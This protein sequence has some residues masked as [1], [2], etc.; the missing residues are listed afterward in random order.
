[1]AARLDCPNKDMLSEFLAG[2]SDDQTCVE[3]ERHIETCN[4]CT[5]VLSRL[6]LV[7]SSRTI[8]E[9]NVQHFRDAEKTPEYERCLKKSLQLDF[10]Y[11]PDIPKAV[12]RYELGEPV[13][14]GAFGRVFRAYD[15]LLDTEVAVKLIQRDILSSTRRD[16]ELLQEIRTTAALRTCPR[17]ATVFDAGRVGRYSYIVSQ[18]IE[19]PRL[20]DV[21]RDELESWSLSQI[22]QV[23]IQI[24]ETLSFAHNNGVVHRDVKP[25]NILL[26]DGEPFL[27]DFGLAF[28]DSDVISGR[29]AGTVP[30]MSPEQLSISEE[31]DYRSDIWSFGVVLYELVAGKRPFSGES[32]TEIRK[33]VYEP[34]TPIPGCVPALWSVI[35]RCLTRRKSKR[36]GSA[37]EIAAD[38]E[39]VRNVLDAPNSLNRKSKKIFVPPGLRAFNESESGELLQLLPGTRDI[40]GI[41]LSVL[42]WKNKLEYPT[43]YE[44]EREAVHYLYGPS[45]AGKSSFVQAALIPQFSDQTEVLWL[46]ASRNHLERDLQD[47]LQQRYDLREP[48]LSKSLILLRKRPHKRDF[49]RLVI[50][51]DQFE[52]WLTSKSRYDSDL[53]DALAHAC[54]EI[55]WLFVTRSEYW[56]ELSEF[57][58]EQ[59]HPLVQE[60][61]CETIKLLDR[62]AGKQALVQLG[63][64]YGGFDGESLAP[65]QQKLV[66]HII[67]ELVRQDEYVNCARLS[68]LAQILSRRQ[69]WTHRSFIEAG[70]LA[71]IEVEFLEHLFRGPKAPAHYKRLVPAIQWIVQQLL[72]KLDSPICETKLLPDTCPYPKKMQETAL[73]VLVQDL[74]LVARSDAPHL[75]GQTGYRIVHEFLGISFRRW[76]DQVDK[77]SVAGRARLKLRDKAEIWEMTQK[78]EHL[79]SPFEWIQLSLLTSAERRSESESRLL[80]KSVA[81]NLSKIAGFVFAF[82]LIGVGIQQLWQHI[83]AQRAVNSMLMMGF[84]EGLGVLSRGELQRTPK[85][86]NYARE[87]ASSDEVRKTRILFNCGLLP[88]KDAAKA[89]ASE[90]SFLK[91]RSVLPQDRVVAST[92]NWLRRLGH[93]ET[94]RGYL[95]FSEQADIENLIIAFLLEDRVPLERYVAQGLSPDERSRLIVRLAELDHDAR[96]IEL[97]KNSSILQSLAAHALAESS[98]VHA[99]WELNEWDVQSVVKT[100]TECPD[101]EVHSCCELLLKRIDKAAIVANKNQELRLEQQLDSEWQVTETG[102]TL[103]RVRAGDY[104]V[105]EEKDPERA[106]PDLLKPQVASIEHD[107]WISQTPIRQKDWLACDLKLPSMRRSNNRDEAIHLQARQA[108]FEFCNTLSAKENIPDSQWCFS[109][110]TEGRYVLKPNWQQLSGYRLPTE[111]EWEV[112]ARANT[113]TQFSYGN[114]LEM[115]DRFGWH[116]IKDQ[117]APITA[118]RLPNP[119][120]LFDV[121]GLLWEWCQD[122]KGPAEQD[123]LQGSAALLRNCLS[124]SESEF[125]KSSARD[126]QASYVMIAATFRV[127]R[128]IISDE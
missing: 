2:R 48:S 22:L 80:Q 64:W 100:F 25:S 116:N 14:Q 106:R 97:L 63:I 21:I 35:Q 23:A 29:L 95:D 50:V 71:E 74:Q 36:F 82:L 98:V 62:V 8:N 16:G 30:Y 101:S 26:R 40:R 99:A 73:A 128:S 112:A 83:S 33:Q 81:R 34:L 68:C 20:K 55:Q 89:I 61:N 11:Q 43:D 120:G 121:H 19:G 6:E 105:G 92:C 78:K 118:L 87:L 85:F 72:P 96:C 46:R 90:L 10:L 123:G 124:Y 57:A 39:V 103:I 51:V 110:D 58:A 65:P 12:D 59:D 70:G 104:P 17:I 115:H 93:A 76:S 126:W 79:P 45:G 60:R 114:N 122:T 84:D 1:M 125:A 37:A 53:V 66:D 38:L 91:G 111:H 15:P 42:Q 3:I 119:F 28:K 44:G 7:D 75:K 54:A 47:L 77:T 127:C 107:F 13:G 69:I 56:M 9:P 108:I 117:R 52:Q 102:V 32:V 109:R 67:E 88:D 5:E 113:Q 41:P 86:S 24:A 18:F 49:K 4:N 94:V 27:V 31:I